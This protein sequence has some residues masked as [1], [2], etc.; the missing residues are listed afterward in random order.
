MRVA[1]F[2]GSGAVCLEE[3]EDPVAGPGEAVLEVAYSAFCGSDKRLLHEGAS[4]VPG[5]EIVGR[6]IELGD[7]VR[8]VSIG[9]LAAV[10]IVLYC[11]SCDWCRSG[12][13]NRCSATAGL[14]GWQVD[15]GRRGRECRVPAQPSPRS[16]GHPD[17]PSG[18]RARHALGDG[19][20]T[21]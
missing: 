21:D 19:Q 3:R 5:H 9:Q 18:A 17:A 14:V 13:T 1:R 15:G 7:G 4:W 8:S 6:V 16:P 12:K 20:P 11:G 2:K 10:Y